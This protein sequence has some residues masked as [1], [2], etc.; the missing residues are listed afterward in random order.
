MCIPELRSSYSL[1]DSDSHSRVRKFRTLDSDPKKSG[2]QL[3]DL[4]CDMLI[5]YLV[6]NSSNKRCT[7]VYKQNCKLTRTV[8]RPKPRST[9]LNVQSRSSTC[10]ELESFFSTPGQNPDSGELR[11]HTPGACWHKNPATPLHIYHSSAME[12]FWH[13]GALQI[14]LLLLLLLQSGIRHRCKQQLTCLSSGCDAMVLNALRAPSCTT[15]WLSSH[16]MSSRLQYNHTST[17]EI[18]FW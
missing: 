17:S 1:W 10:P 12:V 15:A 3:S 8:R 9:R 18:S 16:A 13:S 4:L 2:F 7:I 11:L 14:G 6:L 5:V